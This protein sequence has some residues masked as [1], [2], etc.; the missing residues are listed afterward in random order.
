VSF[1]LQFPEQKAG[2]VVLANTPSV[3]TARAANALADIFIGDALGA[4]APP[5]PAPAPTVVVDTA[6]LDRYAGVYK[7]GPGWY[8]RIYRE[9]S[10]LTAHVR[11]EQP[12]PMTA[13][14]PQEFWVQ[15]YGSA[16]TFATA[17][18]APATQLTYRG[19][20]AVRVAA[21]GLT[22]PRVFVDYVGKYESDELGIAY[23][24]ELRDGVLVLRSRQLGDITL[25]HQWRDDFSGAQGAFRSVEFQR[26]RA[27]RVVGF[28]VNIDERSRDIRFVKR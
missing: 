1:L 17:S 25:T 16:M 10:A 23:P 2:V 13:R 22:P 20:R 14:T 27:G 3:N 24:V 19:R 28:V 9:G 15:N 4:V 6:Q 11:G 21:T 5:P 26:D 12:A 8:V 7:L 18:R